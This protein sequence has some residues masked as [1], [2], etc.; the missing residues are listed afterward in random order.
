MARIIDL[1]SHSEV[2]DDSR[3][4]VEAYLKWLAR[5]T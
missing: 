1:H 2:S 3:A 4:P 5:Q